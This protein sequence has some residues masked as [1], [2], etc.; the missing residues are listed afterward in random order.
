[1]TVGAE[2]AA[3]SRQDDTTAGDA[4]VHDDYERDD[5]PA[6]RLD[7]NYSELL[8]E[9]RVAQTGV[10]F[11]FAFLL[12]LPFQNR[13]TVLNGGQRGLYLSVLLLTAAAAALLIAPV[14]Y[15]RIV[16][17]QHVKGRLVRATNR[18]ALA[19]LVLL[20]AAITGAVLL[21]TSVL[22]GGVATTLIVTATAA[23]FVVFWL[24]V[25]LLGRRRVPRSRTD[26]LTEIAESAE[27]IARG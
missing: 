23:F 18:F 12:T 14:A 27:E 24:V 13:F 10:Q 16:F 21:V 25:P 15:H 9:L 5:T 8:Q 11:L 4:G 22:A 1:M 19:G 17:R 6:Q 7:R 3:T 2:E 26:P 20:A